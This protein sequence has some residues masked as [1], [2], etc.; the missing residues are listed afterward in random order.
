MML[1]CC[2]KKTRSTVRHKVNKKEAIEQISDNETTMEKSMYEII[3]DTVSG[4]NIGQNSVLEL[5]STVETNVNKFKDGIDNLKNEM[6][7]AVTKTRKSIIVVG[8]C[9]LLGFMMLSGAVVFLAMSF[10]DKDSIV[11][12]NVL[13]LRASM[14]FEL[15]A[16]FQLRCVLLNE[17]AE[18]PIPIYG[19]PCQ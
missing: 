12:G 18:G 3:S 16:I 11:F 17:C 4:K 7:V 9:I 1:L 2:N 8:G 6:K 5:K 13:F 19:F 14:Y 10:L 15:L